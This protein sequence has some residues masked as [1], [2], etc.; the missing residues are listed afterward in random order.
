MS[1]KL[2]RKISVFVSLLDVLNLAVYVA[3]LK[4][5]I[6]S[7]HFAEVSRNRKNNH[8]QLW[9]QA[10]QAKYDGLGK[11]FEGEDFDQMLWNYDVR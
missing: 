1:S 2:T 3:L 6:N 8:W 10:L 9:M 5:G 4:L 7:Y 11:P